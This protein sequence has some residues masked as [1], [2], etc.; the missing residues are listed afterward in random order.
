MARAFT[1][2][3][4]AVDMM[5]STLKILRMATEPTIGQM[6][7][8]TLANGRMANNMARVGLRLRQAQKERDTGR[9]ELV[10]AGKITID[11]C[12]FMYRLIN[13]TL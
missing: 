11:L 5:A 3:Q 2:G 4:M 9:M 13:H 10:S 6:D 8:N 1:L 7:A 12:L